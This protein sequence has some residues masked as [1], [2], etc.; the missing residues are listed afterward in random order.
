MSLDEALAAWR[1]LLGAHAVI[2]DASVLAEARTATFATD[3][4]IPAVI[5]PGSRAEVQECLKVA[6]RYGVPVYPVSG[7]KNWGYGSRVPPSDGCTLVDLSRL[8][9][10]VDF[11]EQLAYITVEPGVTFAQVRQFLRDKGSELT[12]A[13]P[14]STPEASLVG[15]VVERGIAAGLDGDRVAQVCGMEVV[16]ADG[17][18]IHTGLKR[19]PGA[20]A[21]DVFAPGVGPALDGLFVQSNLGVVAKMTFWLTPL[22]A[23]WQYFSLAVNAAEKLAPLVDALQEVK[24]Q[25]LVQ[26]SLGL[27]NDYKILTYLRRFPPDASRERT[28]DLHRMPAEYRQALG[29]GVWFG[30]GALTAAS[31]GIGASQRALLC[32]LLEGVTDDLTF[33]EPGA[34]N[35][36]VGDASG[37]SV[38]SVYWRKR[39]APP[40]EMRPDA[41]G[42]GVIWCCPVSPFHGPTLA[43]CASIIHGTMAEFG[44]EPIIGAQCV[45]MRS[46]HVVASIVYDREEPGHDQKAL[47]CHRALTDRLAADGF[48][49]YRL[50]LPAMDALP[51]PADAYGTVLQR[52]KQALDPVDVLSPGRYDFRHAWPDG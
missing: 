27:Y 6:S 23:F 11:D 20:R 19:F 34:G 29:G 36:L 47:D 45:S 28:L 39:R 48:L 17:G 35:P 52:L 13:S 21:G 32:D 31:A 2:T 9:R 15:N 51:R 44:L 4:R 16:L 42:C 14:G 12:L 22:P 37:T 26:T 43:R 24:R 40:A 3:Q 1:D 30:E 5:R 50:A 38:A 10:I 8:N 46:V 33:E 49:P 7:G 25:G 18:C 41:D